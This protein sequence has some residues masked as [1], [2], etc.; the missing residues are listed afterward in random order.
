MKNGLISK[1]D[2]MYGVLFLLPAI[3]LLSVFYLYPI[4]KTFYYSSTDWEILGKPNF[5]GLKNFIRILKNKDFHKSF[6]VTLYYVFGSTGLTIPLAFLFAL[7]LNRMVRVEK[8]FKAI[9]FTPV[10]LST[11]ISSV[12]WISVFHPLG[13]IL[14][15]IRL[16]F[17][18]S[19]QNWYQSIKLVIPGLIIFTLWKGLGLYI[20]IFLSA[21]NNLPDSYYEAARIDGANSFQ[22]TTRIT[23]PLLKPIFLF[24]LV[25]CIVYSFQNFTIVYT[26]TKGGPA[27]FSKILPILIYES[28]FKYFNMGYACSLAVI[29]FFVMFTFSYLQFRI[30]KSE[31]E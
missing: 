6:W 28:G 25:I 29:M 9:Y 1:R 8:I 13:G 21:L 18:L 22:L 4:I 15:L 3:L 2:N 17:G 26:S 12:L 10:V 27:D 24:T 31:V 11:V 7:I 19:N 16:P 20:V 23:I 14:K 5:I 30:F